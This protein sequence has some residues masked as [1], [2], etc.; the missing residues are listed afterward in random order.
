MKK[1]LVLTPA[2]AS[3]G[4]ALAG[5]GQRQASAIAA[6]APIEAALAD[7]ETGV[8]AIDERLVDA[9]LQEW[10]RDAERRLNVAIVALP[11]PGVP[12]RPEDDYVSRLIR[13]A[14]GY[15]VRVQL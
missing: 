10:L 15:Q 13:H 7:G 6:A 3:G 9:A 8:L 5:V 4:F 1:I 11:A 12:A 2:D 14:I